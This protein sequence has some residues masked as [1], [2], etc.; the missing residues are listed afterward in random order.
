M[1]VVNGNESPAGAEEEEPDGPA[2]DLL[3]AYSPE[4]VSIY[5]TTGESL[6]PGELIP[7]CQLRFVEQIRTALAGSLFAVLF[8]PCGNLLVV[9]A[10][11]YLG[12][13][14]PA[15]LAGS[16]I[17]GELQQP[18]V[19]GKRIAV[20]SVNGEI[21]LPTYSSYAFAISKI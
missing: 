17:L 21:I 5:Q 3:L 20:S 2:P 6:V 7:L 16:R 8:S 13:F 9:S 18:C 10:E 15:V 11:Q 19:A 1:N 12:N 14:Q 4:P